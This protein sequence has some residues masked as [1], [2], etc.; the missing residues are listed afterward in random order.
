MAQ[1]FEQA[2]RRLPGEWCTPLLRLPGT[3]R[4]KIREITFR[5]GKPVTLTAAD[6]IRFMDRK[7]VFTSFLPAAEAS[8][9][10]EEV[11]RILRHLTQ[12]SL[13]TFEQ[14]LCGG[15]LTLQGGHRCGI[16]GSAVYKDGRLSH[17]RAVSCISMR[18]ARQ[19]RGLSTTVLHRLYGSATVPSVLLLGAPSGGK[20]TL[21]RDLI[22]ALASGETGRY[23]R[24]AVVD[25]RGEIGA[26]LHGIAQF[27]IGIT[28]ELLDG[29]SK[30]EGMRMALRALSP[31]IIAV[32]EIAA[33]GDMEAIRKIRHSGAAVL[34]TAHA[35]SLTDAYRRDGLGALLIEGAFDYAVILEGAK[36]P[37]RVLQIASV[38]QEVKRICG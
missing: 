34:A 22:R 17:I 24:T 38:Q 12:Y 8:V 32:D 9:S 29:F 10:A 35:A 33:D 4:A 19:V 25:E 27:D 16:A 11:S 21:L 5:A 3:E 7:G 26:A 18:V 2:V 23:F 37:G 20:T 31:E 30:E 6:G 1:A 15:Y 14:E 28:A 13:H 36:H